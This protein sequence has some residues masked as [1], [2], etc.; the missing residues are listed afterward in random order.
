MRIILSR[1]E[2]LACVLS[3]ESERHP[4]EWSK[5]ALKKLLKAMKL[6]PRVRL[7]G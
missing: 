4:G 7:E 1:E 5:S 3:L 2:A 6:K